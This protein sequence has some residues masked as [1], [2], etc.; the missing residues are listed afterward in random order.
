MQRWT[1]RAERV[2]KTAATVEITAHAMQFQKIALCYKNDCLRA[3]TRCNSA[4]IVRYGVDGAAVSGGFS[5]AFERQICGVADNGFNIILDDFAAPGRVECK[6][7]D[8]A[9]RQG[10]IGTEP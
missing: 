2:V 4:A 6:L 5:D 9:A 3:F 10:S 7:L 1:H 8:F